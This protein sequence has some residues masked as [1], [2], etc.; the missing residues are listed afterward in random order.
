MIAFA[1]RGPKAAAAPAGHDGRLQVL[2][3]R[4]VIVLPRLV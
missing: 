4:D 3:L 1:A 2:M